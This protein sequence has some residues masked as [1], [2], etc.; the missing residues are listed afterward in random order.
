M[1]FVVV[2]VVFS[3]A[4]VIWLRRLRF[5][6]Q[7]FYNCLCQSLLWRGT[8][9]NPTKTNKY[10]LRFFRFNSCVWRNP[11]VAFSIIGKHIP[12]TKA[13]H[14]RPSNE[15]REWFHKRFSARDISHFGGKK[16]RK[17]PHRETDPRERN[18]R[19]I[20]LFRGARTVS[21]LYAPPSVRF[22]DVMTGEPI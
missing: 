14:S 20:F 22:K 12:I 6:N 2:V 13:E 7:G 10:V 3:T 15:T 8:K 18:S 19:A 11:V 17:D 9:K 1:F 4:E 16:E 21:A 5:L